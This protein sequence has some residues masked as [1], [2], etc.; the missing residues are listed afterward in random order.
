MVNRTPAASE[1]P[2]TQDFIMVNVTTTKGRNV[3]NKTTEIEET[4]ECGFT[5]QNWIDFDV[6]CSTQGLHLWEREPS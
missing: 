3:E 4:C 1:A 2:R 6:E 5:Y